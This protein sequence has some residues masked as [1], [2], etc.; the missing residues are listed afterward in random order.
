MGQAWEHGVG[1]SRNLTKA[2]ACY[3]KAAKAGWAEGHVW[4]G[5]AALRGFAS[6]SPSGAPDRWRALDHYSTAA[7]MQ[8]AEGWLGL[9]CCR[10]SRVVHYPKGG[11]A[12][13]V[14][15]PKQQL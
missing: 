11:D 10:Y 13:R 12:T 7:A 6:P 9:A 14:L 8:S 5:H 1:V 3:K 2:V 4:L 15:V